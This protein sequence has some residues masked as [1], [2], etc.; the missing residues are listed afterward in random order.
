MAY[1]LSSCT[2]YRE[3]SR[4]LYACSQADNETV[5]DAGALSDELLRPKDLTPSSVE[6]AYR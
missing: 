1:C 4:G 3:E 6:L 5:R 2:E